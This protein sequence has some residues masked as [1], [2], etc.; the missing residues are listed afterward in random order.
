MLEDYLVFIPTDLYQQANLKDYYPEPLNQH[1]KTQN[2]VEFLESRTDQ[3]L[4]LSVKDDAKEG[5][6][7]YI[8]D[9]MEARGS[10][11]RRLAFRGSY[12]AIM[13]KDSTIKEHMHEDNQVSMEKDSILIES[14]GRNASNFSSIKI[15]G[16]EYSP[17]T[18]GINI[19]VLKDGQVSEI[20]TYDTY[21]SI[22]HRTHYSKLR[23]TPSGTD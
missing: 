17:N 7:K 12:V 4:L 5:L 15:N 9:Y 10:Q 6:D 13:E 23:T 8:K 20:A 2:L 22:F 3:T 11:I 21:R 19:V 18:R 16:E 1:L 14:A